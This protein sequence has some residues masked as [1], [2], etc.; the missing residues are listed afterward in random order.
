MKT[1]AR[2]ITIRFTRWKSTAHADTIMYLKLSDEKPYGQT[3]DY[4]AQVTVKSIGGGGLCMRPMNLSFI[5]HLLQRTIIGKMY[6][7]KSMYLIK[8]LD[9]IFNGFEKGN[10]FASGGTYYIKKAGNVGRFFTLV[11]RGELN[12]DSD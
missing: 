8:T 4:I 5:R 11:M 10:L 9:S 2:Q 7:N 1:K 12:V 3:Q 6:S